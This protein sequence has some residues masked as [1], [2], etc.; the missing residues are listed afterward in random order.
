MDGNHQGAGMGKRP[1][2]DLASALPERTAQALCP[3]SVPKY[4]LCSTASQLL[5]TLLFLLSSIFKNYIGLCITLKSNFIL[6]F[7]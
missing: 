4:T 6:L 2:P 1:Y 7:C 5:F 3:A